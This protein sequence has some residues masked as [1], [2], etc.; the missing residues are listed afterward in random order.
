MI[1]GGHQEDNQWAGYGPFWGFFLVNYY[2]ND[3]HVMIGSLNYHNLWSSS[4]IEPVIGGR[5]GFGETDWLG[6][7]LSNP[8]LL[9]FSSAQGG[10]LA[11]L[12]SSPL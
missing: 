12:L 6:I 11:L 7:F 2:V 9:D 3:G 5:A 1:V 10:S 8:E 4:H